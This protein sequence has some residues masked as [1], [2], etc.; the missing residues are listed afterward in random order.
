MSFWWNVLLALLAVL[1]G[2]W[3]N[4]PFQSLDKISVRDKILLKFYWRKAIDSFAFESLVT[5]MK[6]LFK[7]YKNIAN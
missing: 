1:D 3:R 5:P 7:T 6:V 2:T 4:F